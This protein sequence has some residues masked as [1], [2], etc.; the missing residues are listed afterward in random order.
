MRSGCEPANSERRQRRTRFLS[1]QGT[2]NSNFMAAAR[3]WRNNEESSG[4]FT[5]ASPIRCVPHY[6]TVALAVAARVCVLVKNRSYLGNASSTSTAVWALDEIRS[7]AQHLTVETIHRC[8][9]RSKH[10]K[11]R[12]SSPIHSARSHG[13]QNC[14]L[15]LSERA[16]MKYS[17]LGLLW[18]H[19]RHFETHQHLFTVSLVLV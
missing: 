10:H 3:L 8:N 14:F 16:G 2:V 7:A 11:R 12:L 9:F 1:H 4:T 6:E 15:H 17:G 5:A 13:M 18:C 19:D